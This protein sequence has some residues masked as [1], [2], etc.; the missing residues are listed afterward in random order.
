M[1]AVSGGPPEF[2][3]YRRQARAWLDRPR[4]PFTHSVEEKLERVAACRG[5][6]ILPESTARYYVR[7]DVVSRPVAGT[8]PSDV[9]I[10][11]EANRRT[12]H[13]EAFV[14]VAK[15]L[16]PHRLEPPP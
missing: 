9:A 12:D 3:D 10:A 6:V 8:L 2:A 7:P 5:I 14:A 16:I 1:G 4:V 15:E 13:V 11:F